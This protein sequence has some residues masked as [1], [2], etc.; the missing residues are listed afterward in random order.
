MNTQNA[1]RHV[2]AIGFGVA[3]MWASTATVQAQEIVNAE[4]PDGPYVS[5]FQQTAANLPPAAPAT[6]AA[7]PSSD[8]VSLAVPTPAVAEQAAVSVTGYVRDT[9]IASS[10]FAMLLFVLYAIAEIRRNGLYRGSPSRP[11]FTRRAVL[12]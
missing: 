11:H 3:L 7:A 6:D 12:S 1:F 4:F 10:L 8:T 2:I 9:L 5:S